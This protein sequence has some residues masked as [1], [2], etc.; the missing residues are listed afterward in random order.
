MAAIVRV[1]LIHVPRGHFAAAIR[2]AGGGSEFLAGQ[3]GVDVA[4]KWAQNGDALDDDGANDFGG[5][6]YVRVCVAPEVPLVLWIAAV[7]PAGADGGDDG[8]DH[9]ERH[10]QAETD[11]FDFAHV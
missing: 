4:D 9:S 6:P 2:V 5:V 8:D 3:R 7:F 11:L 1:A 10:G